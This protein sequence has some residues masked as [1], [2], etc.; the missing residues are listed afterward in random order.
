[1]IISLHLGKLFLLNKVKTCEK[2]DDFSHTGPFNP[3]KA[4]QNKN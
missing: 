1:M 3:G 4:Y 2:N